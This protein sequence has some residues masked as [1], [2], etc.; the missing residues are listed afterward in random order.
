ML[1][2]RKDGGW[3]SASKTDDSVTN[4]KKKYTEVKEQ[5]EDGM[6]IVV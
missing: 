4:W 5:W 2:T 6:C 1:L 3:Q